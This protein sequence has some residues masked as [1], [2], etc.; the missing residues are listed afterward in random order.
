MLQRAGTLWSIEQ[1]QRRVTAVPGPDEM[2]LGVVEHLDGRQ[3]PGALEQITNL[4][5]GL[6]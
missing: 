5:P 6:S 1:L 4:Q 2:H 3:H